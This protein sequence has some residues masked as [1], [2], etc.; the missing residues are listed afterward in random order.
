MKPRK[1]LNFQSNSEKKNYKTGVINL[2]DFRLYYRA[3][4]IKI[5]EYWHKNRHTD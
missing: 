4:V 3:S 5:A 2:L 1:T